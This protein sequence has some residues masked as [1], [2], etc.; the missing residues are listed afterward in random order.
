MRVVDVFQQ[1]MQKILVSQ[2]LQKQILLVCKPT[3]YVCFSLWECAC[4]QPAG[5]VQTVRFLGTQTA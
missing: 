1:I 4:A 2:E 5:L 3:H